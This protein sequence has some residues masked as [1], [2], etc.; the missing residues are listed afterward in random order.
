[1]PSFADLFFRS[2]LANDNEM[3]SSIARLAVNTCR[4][5]AEIAMIRALECDQPYQFKGSSAPLLTPDKEIAA[6]NI[7]DGI[8]TRWDV[9]ITAEDFHAVLELVTRS[10]VMQHISCLFFLPQ[11]SNIEPMPTGMHFLK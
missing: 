6:D 3:S 11:R 8:I 5:M 10:I 7:K 9:T 4:I 2:G 1:M